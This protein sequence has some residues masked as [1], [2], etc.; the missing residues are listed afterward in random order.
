MIWFAEDDAWYLKELMFWLLSRFMF[1]LSSL[2]TLKNSATSHLFG[3]MLEG[4]SRWLS[5]LFLFFQLANVMKYFKW[6]G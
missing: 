2:H 6:P 5:L 4:S 1:M 3:A